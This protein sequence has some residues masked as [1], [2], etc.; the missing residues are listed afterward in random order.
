MGSLAC[1][2]AFR[3]VARA[4]GKADVEEAL[5]GGS[6]REAR[7]SYGTRSG[8]GGVSHTIRHTGSIGRHWLA[9]CLGDSCCAASLRTPP[10]PPSWQ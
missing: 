3:G 8:G 9:G 6:P 5:H 2:Y 1:V 7:G 10:L 4:K